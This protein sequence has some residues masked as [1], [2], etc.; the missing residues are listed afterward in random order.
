VSL[1]WTIAR[2]EFSSFFRV[3]LGWV[4]M[5][6]YL[7]LAGVIFAERVLVPGEPASLRYFFGVSG[8]LLLPVIPAISMRL[9]SEELRSGT[10]EP[11]MTSPVPDLCI[12]LGKY[13]GAALF[14]GAMLVPTVA[15][16][17]VLMAVS[18]PRPDLGPIIAGYLSLALLGLMYLAVG[19]LASA[20]TANQ[21]LAFLMT[22]LFL[23]VV[24]LI[25]SDVI[26]LPRALA[27]VAG[28]LAIG[29]RLADFAKGVIDTGHIV[30]FLSISAWF[31]V[32]TLV[33]LEMRRWR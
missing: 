18:D 15:Y 32:L 14:L 20:I 29:P 13:I 25:G 30:F 31:L 17:G 28:T 4:A 3:P 23:L 24:M 16:T 33:T 19:L 11:L 2:R 9:I 10:I 22:L 5:A 27:P 26:A 21:T 8:F 7:F 6:L 1:I 12:V